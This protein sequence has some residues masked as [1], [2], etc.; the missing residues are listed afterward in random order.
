ESTGI[1][2][3]AGRTCAVKCPAR[4]ATSQRYIARESAARHRDGACSI[5][6]N[7]AA[8]GSCEISRECIT[9]QR[10]YSRGDG[11]NGAA[12]CGRGRVVGERGIVNVQRGGRGRGIDRPAGRA[13]VAA[14]AAIV[15]RD[16]GSVGKLNRASRGSSLVASER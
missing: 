12:G 13:A 10:Q 4:C 16:G 9:G 6:V 5:E 7:A 2:R 11:V 14:E 15:Q 8:A 3:Q 1:R